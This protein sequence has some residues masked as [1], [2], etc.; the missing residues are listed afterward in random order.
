MNE[1]N[2]IRCDETIEN[3]PLD[4]WYSRKLYLLMAI[5]LAVRVAIAVHGGLG[6]PPL[7][8]SDS[9][10]YDSYA[11]N[12]AQGRGYRGV[13]PDVKTPDGQLLDHPTAFRVPGTSVFW[14]GL[15]WSFGHRYDVVRI[16]QCGLDTLTILLI[17][18]IG[19]RSF[20]NA[21]ALLAAAVYTVWP[22]ALLYSSQLLSDPLYTFIFCWFLLT[23]LQFAER[24]TWTHSIAAGVLLGLAML[25]RGNGVMMVGLLVPWSV[26]QFRRTPRVIVRGLAISFLAVVMLVPWTVRNYWKLHAFVPFDTSG[27]DVMLGSYNRIVA[28]DPHYYGYWIYPTAELPEYRN[29]ITAPNDEVVRDHLEIRLALR[30]MG[31]HP[32]KW[33]YLIESRFRRSWT[34]FLQPQSPML[35]RAGMLVSWG[36]VLTLLILGFIPSA[37]Y[38]VHTNHAGWILHLAILHFVL[39]ALIFWGSSRF[40]YPIEGVCIILASATL[41]W[42]CDYARQRLSETRL[43]LGRKGKYGY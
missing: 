21:V 20:R 26:W 15:Y 29:E 42:L 28:T 22:T 6:T 3:S 35:Y 23:S 31:D 14:A 2:E 24:A 30:W 39:T 1:T 5:G 9:R 40:R 27:G 33:W 4:R 43:L 17:F 37:I 34:P 8:G 10:E 41:I 18:E 7:P 11:W 36:S 32:D 19:R 25:T 13:S 16:A 12:L 38:F